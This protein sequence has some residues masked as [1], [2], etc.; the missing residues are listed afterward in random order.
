MDLR[1]L[2]TASAGFEAARQV[3]VLPAG[4][5]ARRLHGHS[6]LASVRSA[7]PAGWALF[8]G[9]E[10]ERL[11]AELAA[12]TARL[13]YRLLNETLPQQAPTDEN[14]ARWL[15]TQLAGVPGI[16]QIGIQS[17]AH[18]GVDLDAADHAH[19]WRR[20]AFQSAHQL[21]NVAPGH[22]CGRMHGHGFEAIVH[23]DQDAGSRDLSIDYDHLDALW[24]P[25]HAQLDHA[26]L[27]DLPGLHNPTSE[28]LSS[29]LWAR[30]KP[31]LPDLS[32]I[33]V[34]E[35]GS[36]GANFDGS[37]Y[38]IWKEFTLDSALRLQHAPDGSA[39]RRIHGHTYTLRLHLSAPLD[40]V[41]GWTVDF[42]DVK[43]IFDPIF[44]A[45]DHQPL[46]E[47]ADLADND[48]ASIAAWVLR[49][50]RAQ[51]PQLDRVDL[52]ETRGCG[53]IVS[54]GDAGPAL[55]V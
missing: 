46:Y 29:W 22:K 18:Q 45:L 16:A 6:F 52:L 36:C 53:A 30:L 48:T 49:K 5:R 7:L 4:H 11:R 47:I 32:W 41:M 38:R 19:A 1:T 23:V 37:R 28:M 2:F 14:L 26:C 50:A 20:Y 21:P 17:T 24:A 12:C 31:Q 33:T 51:L 10:V 40:E 3:D 39:L 9:G 55:P 35:T 13:D 42:G 27:N 34:Y 8:P 43:T 25:L 44:K 54:A 15:R